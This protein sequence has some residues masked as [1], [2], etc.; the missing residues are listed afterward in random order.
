MVSPEDF[1]YNK[2]THV[3]IGN[4]S[5]SSPTRCCNAPAND[6]PERWQGFE[7]E[8]IARA[9]AAGT[10]VILQLGG[11]GGNPNNV[12]NKATAT[13]PSTER[14]ADEIV[15]YATEQGYDGVELD[16]EEEVDFARVTALAKELRDRWQTAVISVDIGILH[17]DDPALRDLAPIVDRLHVMTYVAIKNWGGDWEGPWHQGALFESLD[18]KRNDSH[19]HSVDRSVQKMLARGVPASKIGIGLGLYGV[20]YN[21]R[22]DNGHCPTDPYHWDGEETY[23]RTLS[24]NEIEQFYEPVMQH[25]I[26]PISHTPWLS[27]LA[28]GASSDP[29]RERLCYISYEN[30]DSAKAKG[31][32]VTRNGLGGAILWSVPQDH[33]A[34]GAYPVLDA[35]NASLS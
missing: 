31:E 17:A 13:T 25:H 10:K 26:D 32:Y 24:L 33:R 27:A 7:K 14:I 15:A 21:D 22:D 12:W 1:P 19:P 6:E 2:M 35:L 16:W 5:L 8:V 23:A 28:P 4:V 34:N 9:H 30:S 3:A 11:E 20:G 29:E 18:G